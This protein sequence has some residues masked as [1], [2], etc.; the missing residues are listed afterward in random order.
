MAGAKD[1]ADLGSEEDELEGKSKAL[2]RLVRGATYVV[3]N[4]PEGGL[5]R[6]LLPVK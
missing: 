2:E 1:L 3:G 5:I 6:A 4:L